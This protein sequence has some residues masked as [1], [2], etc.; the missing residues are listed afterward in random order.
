M[1]G[2]WWVYDIVIPDVTS[3]D[4]RKIII[5]VVRCGIQRSQG[6]ESLDSSFCWNDKH[7]QGTQPLPTIV[8][9]LMRINVIAYHLISNVT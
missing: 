8:G 7:I 3:L 6:Q 2:G 1:G 9:R 5:G 4:N